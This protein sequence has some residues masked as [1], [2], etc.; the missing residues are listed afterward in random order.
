MKK[1]V[2]AS[3]FMFCIIF[4]LLCKI[5]PVTSREIISLCAEAM[6]GIEKINQVKTLRFKA[7]YPDHGDHPMV[8]EMKRPNLS[9]IPTTNLVFDGKRACFLKGQDNQSAPELVDKEEW[10]DFEVENALRFPAFFDYPAEYTGEEIS[11]EKTYYKIAVT[12]PL[13]AKMIYFID[14]ES[15]L[16][17]KITA[18]F[19]LYGKEYHA[20]REYS[21]YREVEGILFSYGFTYGSRTGQL[22]GWI[23]SIEINFPVS[24]DYFTIPADID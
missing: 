16:I 6:G 23:H 8:F 17:A 12:L 10:K 11:N 13:G 4:T 21:D 2:L 20:E 22:K 19:I 14:K 5:K 1:Y 7:I 24:D 3:S 18:D 15:F 9:M